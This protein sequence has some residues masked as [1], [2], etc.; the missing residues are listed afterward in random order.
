MSKQAGGTHA[1]IND[2]PEVKLQLADGTVYQHPGKV[3]KMSG[4]INQAT[5]AVSLIA[6]FPNPEHLLKSGASGTIIVPRVNNNSLVIPQ[7]ATT[8]IQDKVFVYKVGEENRV[9]YTEITVDPQN[10]GNN[11]VVT[12]GLKAGDKIVTRGLTTLT[13]TMQ[14]VPITEAQYLKKV[15]DAAKLG[16]N[17]NSAKGFIDMMKK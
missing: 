4:V 16:K 14:I 12:G 8:E 15:S 1:A 6:R 17:Q 3:V 9:R 10:D 13:D 5:G 7:S 11:Y 2:Y